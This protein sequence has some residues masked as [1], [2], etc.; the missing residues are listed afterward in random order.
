MSAASGSVV[1]CATCGASLPVEQADVVDFGTGY[2]CEACRV[3]GEVDEHL[4]VAAVHERARRQSSY[5][6]DFGPSVAQV[7]AEVAAIRA[8]VTTADEA[9]V[10][11]PAQVEPV[12]QSDDETVME[13]M[14]AGQPRAEPAPSS[15]SA[16]APSSLSPSAPSSPVP[17]YLCIVCFRARGDA[18]GECPRDGVPLSALASLEVVDE[19]RQHVRRAANR[20]EGRRFAATFTFAAV[21]SLTLCV[22]MDWDFGRRG[23][24]WYLSMGIFVVLQVVSRRVVRPIRVRNRVEDLLAAV[25]HMH[26]ARLGAGAAKPDA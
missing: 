21:A 24:G 23:P 1:T 4:R 12:I 3:R 16:S 17:R 25:D 10:P 8:H 5:G 26:G 11:D 15:L 22:L 13:S 19:L 14:S 2:R 9:R 20:R 18:P 6:V 7:K